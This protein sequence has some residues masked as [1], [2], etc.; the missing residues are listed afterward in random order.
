MSVILFWDTSKSF[1]L[2]N[3]ILVNN[4][5]S[6][7]FSPLFIKDIDSSFPLNEVLNFLLKM[8]IIHL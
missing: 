1:N 8:T 3:P 6:L 4:L 7:S 5:K 2:G